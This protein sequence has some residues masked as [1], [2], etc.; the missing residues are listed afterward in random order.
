MIQLYGHLYDYA[1]FS[2][3]SR[4]LAFEL[5]RR[6][7]DAQVY[8][9]GSRGLHTVSPYLPIG[10]NT[11]A[12]VGVYVGY[13]EGGAGWLTGHAERVLVTVCESN[14]IPQ[15]WVDEC[16][17]AT[18]VVVPSEWC[19]VAFLES[20]VKVPV[21]VVPHGVWPVPVEP[22]PLPEKLTLLH[23]SGSLTFAA[24]K[25]T[26][27]L[28]RAFREFVN[29]HPEARLLLKMPVTG[30]VLRA[31]EVVELEKHVT[32][33]DSPTLSPE[34]M[35]RLLRRV[36]AVVQ[37]SRAEGFGIVPLEARYQGTPVVV[38]H[39]TGHWDHADDN[40]VVVAVGPMQPIQ[41]QVNPVGQ[42][43]TVEPAAV[44]AALD[45]LVSC[46]YT[47]KKVSVENA[48]AHRYDDWLW[49]RVLGPFVR[50]LKSMD[51]RRHIRL[52]GASGLRGTS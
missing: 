15:T 32:V 41:T 1:S 34:A 10:L 48:Q 49:E 42:A 35:G 26:A 4:A 45:S 24:R 23:V 44:K 13:P 5:R 20:G 37:P 9:I 11:G 6:R 29:E 31:I 19:R 16:N 22:Q 14:R 43:P 46:L 8:P 40:D 27:A 18:L 25:G 38:T 36:H 30:G 12:R 28:L 7:A 52:G 3:V 47:R 17:A 39:C 50:N 33:L 2:N 21:E 51:E